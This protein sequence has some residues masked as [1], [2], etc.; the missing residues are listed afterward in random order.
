M[1]NER[2]NPTQVI[3]SI[4]HSN[5]P[6]E[7]FVDVLKSHGVTTVV[8]V[9][10]APYSRFMPCYNRPELE[11]ALP[12]EGLAY[13]Y[14]GEYLGGRP[15]DPSL[16]RDGLIPDERHAYLQ[17]VNY[18]LLAQTDAVQRGLDRL[19]QLT[20]SETVAIMC[21][22]EDPKQCHR[23]HLIEHALADRA[24]LTHIRTERGHVRDEQLRDAP[25]QTRLV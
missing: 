10:S 2:S 20:V 11:H 13:R 22:E 6:F 1:E 23:H 9:R 19:V 24:T 12:A 17:N 3:Y 5:L 18:E 8:D 7:R 14:A 4:G 15:K 21:S 25:M 16:Y